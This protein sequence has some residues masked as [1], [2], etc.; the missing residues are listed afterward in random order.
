MSPDVYSLIKSRTLMQAAI[1]KHGPVAGYVKSLEWIE[2]ELKR[3]LVARHGPFT[4]QA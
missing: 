3:E 4:F 1:E 2:A